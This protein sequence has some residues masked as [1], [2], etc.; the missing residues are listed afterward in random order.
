MLCPTYVSEV[1]PHRSL[2]E[3]VGT[4]HLIPSALYTRDILGEDGFECVD[5]HRRPVRSQ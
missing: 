4:A 5:S 1:I 2:D 3:M